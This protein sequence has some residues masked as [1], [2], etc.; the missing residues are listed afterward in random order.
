VEL[1]RWEARCKY[2]KRAADVSVAYTLYDRPDLSYSGLAR[3]PYT[4]YDTKIVGKELTTARYKTVVMSRNLS[5]QHL[6]TCIV[7]QA[8]TRSRIIFG[9]LE[10]HPLWPTTSLVRHL[11]TPTPTSCTDITHLRSL[12][13]SLLFSLLLQLFYTSS[14]LSRRGHGIS[15]R[16]SLG[17]CVRSIK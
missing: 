4:L 10:A 9:L 12:Q 17:A 16:W 1:G 11:T 13:L 6:K 5:T 15:Y 7:V 8:D 14:N 3:D 2:T